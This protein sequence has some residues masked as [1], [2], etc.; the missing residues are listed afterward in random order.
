VYFL[1]QK[2]KVFSVFKKFQKIVERQI[3]GDVEYNF[4]EFDKFYKDIGVER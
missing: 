3:D 1:R 2:L 4:K